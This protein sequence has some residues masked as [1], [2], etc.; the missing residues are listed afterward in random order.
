MLS[1][2]KSSRWADS[3]AVFDERVS[4]ETVELEWKEAASASSSVGSVQGKG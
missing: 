2:K 4:F 3:E 1:K